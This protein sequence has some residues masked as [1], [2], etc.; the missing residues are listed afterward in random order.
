MP[1]TRLRE[2][3]KLAYYYTLTLHPLS[4]NLDVKIQLKYQTLVLNLLP[5]DY[6]HNLLFLS[7]KHLRMFGIPLLGPSTLFCD[8]EA[9]YKDVCFDK[10]TLQKK[11]NY[12]CFHSVVEFVASA[13]LNVHKVDIG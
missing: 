8:N 13:I 12:I 1:E 10:Y 6:P 9:V 2:D 7:D 4:G 5:C 3:Q 11:H